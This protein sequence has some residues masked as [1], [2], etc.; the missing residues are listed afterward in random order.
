M[1]KTLRIVL[2]SL[3][4]PVGLALL[5]G[6]AF[7]GDRLSNGGQV[8]GR[9]LV[10]GVDLGDLNQDDAA[11]AVRNLEDY[12]RT[13]PVPVTVAGH[14]FSLDPV[15]VSFEI[16]EAAL[17]ARAMEPGRE[18]HLGSQFVWWVRRFFGDEGRTLDLEYS[19]DE[20][21]LMEIVARWELEGIDNPAFPG[22][23]AVADGLVSFRHPQS[24]VGIERQTAAATSPGKAGLSIPSSSHRA[25]ISMRAASS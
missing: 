11:A 19:Y 1:P 9:V 3:L 6:L 10:S 7:L 15:A 18:G 2:I 5:V 14:V 23:V 24:G 8:L 25:T 20:A 13:T 22:E 4:V 17:A 12:L 21:A 16:D